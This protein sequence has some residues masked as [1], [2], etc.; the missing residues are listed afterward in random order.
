MLATLLYLKYL[1]TW[2]GRVQFLIDNLRASFLEVKGIDMVKIPPY[3]CHNN[4]Y[5]TISLMI[6]IFRF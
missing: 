1:F 2:S 5:C 3:S 6:K 4:G